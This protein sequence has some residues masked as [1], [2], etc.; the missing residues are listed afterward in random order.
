MGHEGAP[1]SRFDG[2][3]EA[4]ICSATADQDELAGGTLSSLLIADRP[5]TDKRSDG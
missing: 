5:R 2:D 1:G 4:V 3:I